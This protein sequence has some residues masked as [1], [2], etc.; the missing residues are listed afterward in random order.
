MIFYSVVTF[1]SCKEPSNSPEN[2]SNDSLVLKFQESDLTSAVLTLHTA[3][4]TLPATFS[5]NRI[6]GPSRSFI[7]HQADT[8]LKDSL[9]MPSTTYSWRVEK[10]ATQKS[11]LAT[12]RTMDTT[13]HEYTWRVD[14]LG[15]TEHYNNL[16][17]I[18]IVSEN[19]IW[20][21][22]E[23][24]LNG[25]DKVYGSVHWDGFNWT[26]IRAYG[27][28][29]LS[30]PEPK[31]Q[32]DLNC[33]S[34]TPSNELF[35]INRGLIFK[36]SANEWKEIGAVTNTSTNFENHL[37][38]VFA[39]SDHEIYLGGNYGGLFCFDGVSSTK[40]ET[41]TRFHF[42]DIEG[43]PR[44]NRTGTE[45][46]ALASAIDPGYPY[47]LNL[48]R[49]ENR[50]LTQ[51][52]SENIPPEARCI[53]FVPDRLYLVGARTLYTKT[54]MD[55]SP[56]QK[57]IVYP[58][59]PWEIIALGGN[60]VNDY[61]ILDNRVVHFNGSTFRSLTQGINLTNSY[62]GCVKTLGRTVVIGAMTNEFHSRVIIYTGKRL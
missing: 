9:L 49:I 58:D 51:V 47:G 62:F 43:F 33:I 37:R 41:G 36:Y 39:N 25:D 2:E 21:V 50:Q 34:L 38:S 28:A 48:Y 6:D 3:G 54:K 1:T 26:Y 27:R 59:S 32:T 30:S 19:N 46:I 8:T 60:D 35:G 14:T 52:N 18:Q 55:N 4:I 53:W 7:L 13:S 45:I 56:W 61:F 20:L 44:K 10:S 29:F 57:S 11:N 5:L 24:Y 42:Y 31:L 17:K 15:G 12:G 23:F 22:G 16:T 40:I